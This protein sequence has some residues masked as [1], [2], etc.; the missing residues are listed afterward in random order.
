VLRTKKK[1]ASAG[2][3]GKGIYFPTSR[4]PIPVVEGL[5]YKYWHIYSYLGIDNSSVDKTPLSPQ[6][7]T[8]RWVI[9]SDLEDRPS[10]QGE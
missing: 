1:A 10:H 2:P 7:L 5:E 8:K 9:K 6:F 4:S 3:D